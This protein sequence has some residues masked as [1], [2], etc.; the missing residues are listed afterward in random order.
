MSTA[1]MQ[2]YLARLYTDSGFRRLFYRDEAE[3]MAEYRLAPRE[4][5][6]LTGI[7]RRLLEFFAAS[8][9]NKRRKRWKHAY[10]AL[11]QLD[12][13]ALGRYCARYHDIHPLRPG[14]PARD[15][16][17]RFGRF[18]SETLPGADDLPPY[19][20]DLIRFEV[21]ALRLR[22]AD[23]GSVR[24]ASGLR[25]GDRPA[26][27]D[28]VVVEAFEYNVSE[29]HQALAAG[30]E[31]QVRA[32]PEM[33]IGTGAVMLAAARPTVWLI[34]QCDG[35]RTLREI[36]AAAETHFGQQG[37]AGTIQA[38]LEHL[39]ASGVLEAGAHDRSLSA[40]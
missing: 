36:V 3:T 7:D 2:A 10:P 20:A 1:E 6:A 4:R 26:R 34:G 38:T 25:A 9:L 5:Q 22:T 14:E 40:A 19:T 15:E 21:M 33:V 32:E 39:V 23:G 16:I 27:A 28:G 18:M 8:L 24:R 11:F 31:P 37:L 29:I 30:T 35:T 13:P 17:L 12:G